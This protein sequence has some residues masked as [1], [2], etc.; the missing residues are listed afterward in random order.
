VRLSAPQRRYLLGA[1]YLPADLRAIIAAET[2]GGMTLELDRDLA[3][4]FRSAF[5]ERLAQA[6][7]DAN[8][9]LTGEGTALEELIEAFFSGPT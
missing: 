6:G 3:E 7:F 4:R 8:Y 1:D 9:E 2:F 5:T